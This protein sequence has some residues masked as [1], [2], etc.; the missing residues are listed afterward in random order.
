MSQQLGRSDADVEGSHQTDRARAYACLL[1]DV[2]LAAPL[3]RA[4]IP[5]AA[6]CARDDPLRFSRHTREWVEWVD[7]WREPQRLVRR[8]VEWAGH[9]D[10]MP[11]LYY[12][13]DGD[14]LLV[15]RHR[16]Q[17]AKVFRFVIPEPGLVEDLA[18]KERFAALAAR[19]DLPVPP[20]T[21][22]RGELARDLTGPLA[23]P[24]VVKPVTRDGLATAGWAAKA[25]LVRSS[26]ELDRLWRRMRAAGIARALA[27]QL[28][29]GPESRVESY[30][31]YVDAAGVTAGE[32]T[33]RKLRTWPVEFGH[34]TAVIVTAIDDVLGAG[35]EI[36][37]RL[38]LRGVVKVDYKRAP[39][40]RLILLE[41]NP[42]FNLWHHPGAVAGVDLPGLVYADLTEAPRPTSPRLRERVAWCHPWHD[43]RAAAA[44]GMS[45]LEWLGWAAR[46]ETR[47][48]LS[49]RDPMPFLRGVLVRK[50]RQLLR[51]HLLGRDT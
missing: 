11:V 31:A 38:N 8:L 47:H 41:V 49:W 15:S 2:D 50:G 26:E 30:H 51:R 22:L 24:L 16:A 25:A 36:V 33:G 10:V 7:H 20:S 29:P 32:F 12:Q 14:L 18:D 39:D 23:F 40:G 9:Q 5:V 3:A 21:V 35:R 1:G 43:V 6:V 13:T 4:R 34:S 37:A 48:D 28:V 42:R 27:Q 45:T 17:L 44:T 46:C 19:L